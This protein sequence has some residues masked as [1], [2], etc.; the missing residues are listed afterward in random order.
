MQIHRILARLIF[1]QIS[2]NQQAGLF[3]V[4][5]GLFGLF[6]VFLLVREVDDADVS[7]LARHENSNGAPDAGTVGLLDWP[8]L[9]SYKAYK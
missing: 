9:Y 5:D 6:G 8:I 1:H 3:L 2:R 7:V 4:L